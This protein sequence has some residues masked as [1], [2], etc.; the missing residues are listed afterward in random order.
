MF[1]VVNRTPFP[2]ALV[3]FR[4]L[5]G[6][7]YLGLV[8]KATF[9]LEA[10]YK[11]PSA[12]SPG[13]IQIAEEQPP[14]LTSD[15]RNGK[16]PTASARVL[17]ELTR[18]KLATD[19]VLVGHACTESPRD[20]QVDVC[21]RVGHHAKLVRVF[22]ERVWCRA[23]GEWV[24][25]DTLPFE[26]MPLVYERAYGGA[27][28]S[29]PA[30][31]RHGYEPRNPAGT[32]FVAHGS[33]VRLEGLRLPNL[34]DPRDLIGSWKQRPNPA[35]FGYVDAQSEWRSR[36][37]G[38]YDDAWRTQRAPLLPLDFDDRFFNA[39]HPEL[40][41][42]GYLQGGELVRVDGVAPRQTLCFEVPRL[43]F[44]AAASIHDDTLDAAPRLDTLWIDADAAKLVLLYR[45]AFPTPRSGFGVRAVFVRRHA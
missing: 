31:V 28:T 7:D 8:I 24:I 3:P 17:A 15:L 29:D 32:G 4:D 2:A 9:E 30:P 33:S 40:I 36:Y 16:T 27:D 26:R 37:A 14:P 34:E 18:P 41:Y 20:P 10:A 42:P 43:K 39:A 44:S 11:R 38:T 25:S 12:A 5:A 13:E 35:G 23:V 45:A 21:L 6:R 22:G 1:E 19:L